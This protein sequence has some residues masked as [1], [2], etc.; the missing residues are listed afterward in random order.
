VL[1]NLG[2]IFKLQ[3]R[4]DEAR[5]C[6]D[7]TLRIRPDY[8]QARC[9]RALMDLADGK[10]AEGWADY[11]YRSSYPDFPR[12][13]WAQPAWRGEPLEGRTLLVHAE[14]GLGDTLQFVRYLH[15]LA[16]QDRKLVLEVSPVLLPLLG[17]SGFGQWARL[18]PKGQPLPQFD[19]Q[20]PLLSLP[21]IFK[22]TLTDIP[23]RVPY[24]AASETLVK[25]WKAVLG[26]GPPLKVGIAWQGSATY[27]GDRFRSVPL[28]NFAPLARPNVELISLQCGY[29]AEQIETIAGKFAVRDLGKDFDHQHGAF[30]DTAAV[31]R[32][33]DLVVTSDTAVAHLAGALG[34]TVWVAL[35]LSADWRWL[36]QR[37]DSPWYPTMTLFRQATFDDWQPVFS[38]MAAALDELVAARSSAVG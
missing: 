30:M 21:G 5:V 7:Q 35:Q 15:L 24:L 28:L 10:L 3:G 34:V 29:G 11:E 18:V 26:S 19:L 1:N 32:N 23:H 2:N 17:E 13:A 8:M 4:I 25:Q 36:R 38:R 9:N 33:L 16:A 22:T 6:Y 27:S 20:V 37:D 12:R 31:I 14:Q